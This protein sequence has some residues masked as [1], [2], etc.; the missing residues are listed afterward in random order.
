[1]G[2]DRDHNMGGEVNDAIIR[3]GARP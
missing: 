1:M 3:H 2:P